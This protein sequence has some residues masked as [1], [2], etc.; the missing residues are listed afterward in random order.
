MHSQLTERTAPR[1]LHLAVSPAPAHPAKKLQ[2]G[3]GKQKVLLSQE[4]VAPLLFQFSCPLT[5]RHEGLHLRV[6]PVHA[7][8]GEKGILAGGR[9]C[10]PHPTPTS[11]SCLK[12]LS[13]S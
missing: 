2:E 7:L 4:A 9:G 8:L 13:P 11:A 3:V 1:R 10:V 12:P 5:L 6:Q